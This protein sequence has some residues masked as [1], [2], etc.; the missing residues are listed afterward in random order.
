M[1]SKQRQLVNKYLDLLFRR[2][3]LIIS[4][5]L[6]SLPLG[7]G[8]YLL[9]PKVYQ[10]SSLLSYQQQKISPNKLS[11]DVVSRI[12]DIVSTLTQIVTSRTNLEALIESLNLYPEARKK[13]PMEDVVDSMRSQIKIEPLSQGDIFKIVFYHG[14]PD[15][16][17][18]V[19]NALAAKFIEENL[20]YREERASE[21][22]AYTSDELLMAKEMMDR[23]ESA[24]RDYKV[25][26][27]NEMPEQ[28]MT[29]MSR[30]IALQNQYQLKQQS[31]QNLER[32]LV[33]IQDRKSNRKIVLDNVDELEPGSGFEPMT[34]SPVAQKP[35][36]KR[37][38]LANLKRLLDQMLT[39][40]T[41]KH[42]EVKRTR[43]IINKLEQDLEL[44]P[45]TD[46]AE[47]ESSLALENELSAEKLNPA[48]IDT[49]TLQL[50]TQ[51][52]NVLLNIEN[53][54]TEMVD[55]QEKITQYE[56]WVSAA[57]VREAEWSALTREYGQLKRHYEYL[58][59]QDLEA[60]SMLNL[61]R[62]QKGSQFKIEDPARYPEKPIKPD[63]FL[64]MATSIMAG[65][66]TGLA[67]T[68]AFDFFDTSFRDPETIE[69]LLGVP[70]LTTVPYVATR[71]E[72]AKQ[73]RIL[74]LKILV[75][76]MATVSIAIL[77]LYVW[78]RGHIVT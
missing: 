38:Q 72:K 6:I 2:K 12:R 1:D 74:V 63:F 15:K 67:V 69:S 43:S 21:T 42:P 30:L 44:A 61:E 71:S 25:K 55:L 3:G 32:T 13:L 77:F 75:L 73:K 64:I 26:F 10:A 50:E 41:E 51:R 54:K 5:L 36:S 35:M 20:K 14:D 37:Q 53:L 49:I 59:T 56:M 45:E 47:A 58:V 28:R 57:P 52:K 27:Y 29:N 65:L 78:K 60:K 48:T 16:A 62:R 76:L 9:T 46:E 17:V 24:M 8:A 4:V 19:T 11:P 34:R 33:L 39:R 40:Y 70:L 68:L 7:L 23:K 22:S 18:K 31:I 66:G